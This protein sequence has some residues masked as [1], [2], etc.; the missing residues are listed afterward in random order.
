M[1]NPS[2]GRM[3]HAPAGLAQ[4]R[5]FI[6]CRL[7]PNSKGK[8]DK[9]TCDAHGNPVDKDDS[10]HWGWF[11]EIAARPWHVGFVLTDH[12]PL[13]CVDLDAAVVGN[14]WT[15]LAAHEMSQFPG[16]YL[17]MSQSGQGVHVW[18]TGTLP[19]GHR[20]RRGGHPVEVYTTNRFI[21][22]G[23]PLGG[24]AS[25]PLQHHLTAC[26]QRNKLPLEVLPPK[27]D[28]GRN[29]EWVGLEDDA[30]LIRYAVAQIPSGNQMMGGA[31]TFKS[32]WE[33]DVETFKRKF[34]QGAGF[35]H[36]AIDFSL[37]S[38][39]SYFTGQDEVRM[40]RLFQEWQGYRPEK[41]D[42]RPDLLVKTVEKGTSNPNVLKMRAAQPVAAPVANPAKIN[43][44]LM[45]PSGDEL[46]N[47]LF[48]PLEYI[49][50][51]FMP[52]GC[53]LMVGEAKLGKTWMMLDLAVAVASGGEFMGHR[54]KQ[55]RV[56][57]LALEESERR[58]NARLHALCEAKGPETKR[59]MSQIKFGTIDSEV[60]NADEGLY[61]MIE[62]I[63][64]SDPTI[65][66]LVLD[67]L[68]TVRPA[69]R[70]GEGI[71]ERDRRALDP[72]TKVLA[73]RPG[74]SIMV[75]HHTRK[76]KS[77]NVYESASG[78][79]GL[80]GAVD[81]QI[82]LV[83]DSAGQTVFHMR[84]RDVETYQVTVQRNGVLWEMGGDP[85][86][87]GLSDTRAKIIHVL[88]QFTAGAGASPKTIAEM[89]GVDVNTVNQRL[90][91]MVKDNQ[92]M[93]DAKR[94]SYILT[95]KGA[96]LG[97][98]PAPYTPISSISS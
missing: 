47:K 17:E 65:T 97:L 68:H 31:L 57:Y 43:N 84:G 10:R 53:W 41:Y 56:M 16:A 51:D 1:N 66:L 4:Y 96:S 67:T 39:L 95:P 22:L 45:L 18:G 79:M 35:D 28:P 61:Q 49:V 7:V 94:G 29:P 81:G 8:F 11:H 76:A 88:S 24:D 37:M 32:I 5:Q 73:A 90:R 34:P 50:D 70:N 26:M 74:R 30:A 92:V 46:M 14:Q 80:G 87:A 38:H 62:T 82:V 3:Q 55:G 91:S 44:L 93:K 20:T 85:E 13:F 54:C 25:T 2:Q 21:M 6:S 33:Y 64:D 63:F 98:A 71:Y 12:D 69:A 23:T 42:K 77:D 48:A 60:P 40:H 52:M 83:T 15:P 59:W 58:I 75:V 9:V 19:K 78:S 72:L 86:A 27:L 36:S 89:S